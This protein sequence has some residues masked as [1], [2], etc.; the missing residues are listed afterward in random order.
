MFILLKAFHFKLN[1]VHYK[2]ISPL[3]SENSIYINSTY[4]YLLNIWTLLT[5]QL[6]AFQCFH[7]FRRKSTV[8]VDISRKIISKMCLY[9]AKFRQHD[10]NM[11]MWI[12]V[13]ETFDITF[14]YL[15]SVFLA[16]IHRNWPLWYWK[17]RAMLWI[18]LTFH[19]NHVINSRICYNDKHQFSD[20]I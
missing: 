1:D 13:N 18:G 11:K 12:S 14:L 8:Y 2:T 20:L 9:V 3:S 15:S 17:L 5:F 10:T 6:F 16:R 7:I 4:I 19:L